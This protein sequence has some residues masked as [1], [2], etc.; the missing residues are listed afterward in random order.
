MLLLARTRD[1]PVASGGRYPTGAR[2]ESACV[3]VVV[4]VVVVAINHSQSVGAAAAAVLH[5]A[6]LRGRKLRSSSQ[7]NGNWQSTNANG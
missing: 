5:E 7:M 6:A 2:R 4:V 1:S 3:G